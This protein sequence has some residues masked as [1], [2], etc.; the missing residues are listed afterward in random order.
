MYKLAA[1]ATTVILSLATFFTS[2]SVS[3]IWQGAYAKCAGSVVAKDTLKIV[4]L[5]WVSLADRA[6]ELGGFYRFLLESSPSLL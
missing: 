6:I 4:W 5:G 2:S 1:I 3:C